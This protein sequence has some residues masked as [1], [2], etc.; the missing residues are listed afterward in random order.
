MSEEL[1]NRETSSLE[2]GQ[3]IMLLVVVLGLFL[4]AAMAFSTDY[5]KMWFHRQKAQAAADAVCLAG[6]EDMMLQ[7]SGVTGLTPGF[8]LGT[9][10]NC[11]PGAATGTVCTYAK[12]NGY[13][14]SAWNANAASNFVSWTFPGSVPGVTAPSGTL[15]AYPFLQVNVK[16]NVKAMFSPMLTGNQFQ[17][18]QA[19][20]TCGLVQEYE[21]APL[22]VL[23]PT[24]KGALY[25][26]GG[27]ALKI[28]GGP[29][30][31]IIVDSNGTTSNSNGATTAIYCASS[32]VID[33]SQ[34]GPNFTGSAVGTFG[35]PM[36]P[37]SSTNTQDACYGTNGSDGLAAGWSGGTTGIWDWPA[38]PVPDP[39]AAVVAP[40]GMKSITPGTYKTHGN[41]TYYYNLA[42]P[43]MDG[44]PD[45]SPTDYGNYGDSTYWTCGSQYQSKSWYCRGCHE[46]APGYYPNGISENANDV[47][48]FLPGVYYLDGPLSIGGSDLIR[49]AKPCANSQGVVNTNPTSGNCS[50]YT[51]TAGPNGAGG[52]TPWTHQETDGVMFFF[53][54]TA[55]LNISGCTGCPN[56][57]RV[58]TVPATDL[59]CNGSAPPSYLGLG[60]SLTGN[61]LQA[62]CTADGT[63][64]DIAGDGSDSPGSI[65]GL[66]MFQDHADTASPQFQGSANLAYTGT[67][68]FHSSTY[69]TIFQIPGGTFSNTL[70]WGNIV[71][72]QLQMTG[73][74][75]LEMGLNPNKTTQLLKVGLFQ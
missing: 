8:T 26:S 29:S 74:G 16:E 71:T 66:L 5:T 27:A 56:G 18:V 43:E 9:S 14:P 40:A 59:T 38:T 31:S 64:W 72:D 73:S 42:A 17:V 69:G 75:V 24:I 32:G 45:Q 47:I 44:C 52:G 61:I 1:D 55:A 30:R 10:G 53:H 23:H 67:L 50:P 22:M 68:Y 25:Y 60:S 57:T 28:L 2:K 21:G 51:Q 37:P 46:Y 65:R 11:P 3:A 4:L 35:G 63:Y 49:M 34:G 58:D 33:T 48:T 7:I 19:Q 6:A 39:Y 15:T 54:G 12:Y 62:T 36:L 13:P 20:S 41:G 70:I